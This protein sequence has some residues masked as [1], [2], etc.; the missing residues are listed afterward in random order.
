[1][2]IKNTK[3]KTRRILINLFLNDNDI[4][5]SRPSSGILFFLI[6]VLNNTR[7]IIKAVSVKNLLLIKSR[8]YLNHRWHF[9]VKILNIILML[10]VIYKKFPVCQVLLKFLRWLNLVEINLLF[11]SQSF[12]KELLRLSLVFAMLDLEIL[13]GVQRLGDC[14]DC[15]AVLICNF[16]RFVLQR[17]IS[18]ILLSD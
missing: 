4:L 6:S 16:L 14:S 1:M 2:P 5:H 13:L 3:H 8:I 15:L 17:L 11:F 10:L 7:L 9:I 12:I 18:L